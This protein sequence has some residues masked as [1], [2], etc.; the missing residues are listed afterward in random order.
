MSKSDKSKNESS[1]ISCFPYSDNSDKGCEVSGKNGKP[2]KFNK[3]DFETP[4]LSNSLTV[5]FYCSLFK[6]S[7]PMGDLREYSESFEAVAKAYL[8]VGVPKHLVI[9][10]VRDIIHKLE[11]GEL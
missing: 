1:Q 8:R 11:I 6:R 3:V 4:D 7:D 2:A 5:Q 10:A 9:N